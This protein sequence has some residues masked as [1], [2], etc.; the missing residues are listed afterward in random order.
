ML[1][2]HVGHDNHPKLTH[3]LCMK[4]LILTAHYATINH[5]RI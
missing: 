1:N 5:A 3:V 2:K 4:F